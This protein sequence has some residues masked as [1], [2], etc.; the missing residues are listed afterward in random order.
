M[1]SRMSWLPGSSESRHR[2][3][4]YAL[5][6][7]LQPQDI[8]KKPYRGLYCT[9]C[10]DFYLERDLVDGKC[11][12]HGTKPVL[13]EEENIYVWIDALINYITGQGFGS[14]DE[15]RNIWTEEVRKIHVI[16]KNVW[17]FHTVYW[18]ALLLSAGLPLPNE[19]VVHG[20]LTVEGKK[21]SKSLGNV[22]DPFDCIKQF[23]FDAF[24]YYLLRAV[25]PFE[26]GDYSES[27]VVNLYNSDLANGL[28][29]LVSRLWTLCIKSG[30]DRIEDSGSSRQTD[31]YHESMTG[32]RFGQAQRILWNQLAL[33]NQEIDRLRPWEL[34]RSGKRE[35]VKNK[36][37]EWVSELINTTYNKAI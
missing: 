4:V 19:I 18:P 3:G 28:G 22:A 21:M 7:R 34:L 10:E 14:G 30:V 16:G 29:N 15:W 37:Q 20:F 12:D 31:Q 11:P 9:G 6:K 8:Y 35:E 2:R 26:D 36:T 33:I 24:R 25:S 32:C 5:W 13:V 17:K 1:P 23:G 27:Q